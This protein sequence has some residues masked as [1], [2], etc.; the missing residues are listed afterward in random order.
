ML[1]CAIELRTADGALLQ[2]D[3]H[4]VGAR[5]MNER[6]QRAF[7]ARARL[8]VDQPHAA[9]LQLRERGADVVDAQGDVV[10]PGPALRR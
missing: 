5:R 9:R 6:D 4:A 2:L 7:G 3:E 1:T 10:Q 8:L